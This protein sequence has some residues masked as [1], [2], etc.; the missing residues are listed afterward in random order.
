MATLKVHGRAKGS[1]HMDIPAE[2]VLAPDLGDERMA[3]VEPASSSG[4]AAAVLQGW[5]ALPTRSSRQARLAVVLHGVRRNAREY[6]ETWREWSQRTHRPVLAPHF[7]ERNWPGAQAYNLGNVLT[8]D[9]TVKPRRMWAFTALGHLIVETQ[10][11][12]GLTDATWDLFGHSA[13]AQLAHRF[14]LL[15]ADPTLSRVAVAG[16]G[17]FT[18][19]DPGIDW[20]YGTRHPAL[21]VDQAALTRWLRRPLVLL[22]GEH[23][24]H[25][26]EHLRVG[27]AADAQ[28]RTRW[29]RAAHMLA[30]GLA[31]DPDCRWELVEVA[32]AGHNEQ[33][34]APAVQDR[35]DRTD[36]LPAQRRDR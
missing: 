7:D 23:D 29:D 33:E 11:R 17:W 8:D 4:N 22:R 28:G 19:P 35:W 14:A 21:G 32:G 2:R 9:G 18:V 30:V 36:R 20:P 26:D 6:L 15:Q 5:V 13:G 24:R 10:S 3:R 27:P 25:R 16:A 12:A 34:I 1:E 31:Q